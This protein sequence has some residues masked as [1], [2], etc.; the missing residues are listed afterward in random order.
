MRPGRMSR[1]VFCREYAEPDGTVMLTEPVPFDFVDLADNRR[2]IVKQ[3]DTLWGLAA[4][5]FIADK[6]ERPADLWWIIADFQ[7]AP[8]Y[9][10]TEALTPGR[11]LHI[12]SLRTLAER[13][14]SAARR[15]EHL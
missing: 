10:P 4:L 13:C 9:D 2:H 14:F 6:I 8:I 11:V 12:P 5:Y 1:Y 15:R 3:G 7:P